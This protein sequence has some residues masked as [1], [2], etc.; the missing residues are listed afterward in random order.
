MMNC[1]ACL[2]IC[3][4]RI[5]FTM[6]TIDDW[7]IANDHI[8]LHK[9]HLVILYPLYEF[10]VAWC[11]YFFLVDVGLWKV[12]WM[13]KKVVD[14][15]HLLKH[16]SK[17]ICYKCWK[18]MEKNIIPIILNRETKASF[19]NQLVILIKISCLESFKEKEKILTYQLIPRLLR[20]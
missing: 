3:Y 7:A 14:W 10:K 1:M 2:F 20:L 6:V 12:L 18:H 4:D 8:L 16:R 9:Y 5:A 13:Q 19:H 15:G 11:S 17:V